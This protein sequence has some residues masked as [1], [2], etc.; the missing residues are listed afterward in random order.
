[1][2]RY[3]VQDK[4]AL[5]TGAARGIGF[6]T[7]RQLV[8]RGARVALVDLDDQAT[9]DAAAQLGD[10][11]IGFGADVT[12]AAAME[13]VVADAVAHFGRLDVVVAN[14]GI[15]PD[16]ATNR[17][18]GPAAF[19]RVLDVNVLGVYRT[20]HA[21]L[22]HVT[23]NAGHVVVIASVYAF[24]NGTILAPYAMSKAAVEQ[25]GRALRAELVAHG[26]SATVVYF[27]F[28]DTAMVREGFGSGIGQ[29]FE[30][31]FP[32]VLRKRLAPS[33]AG[34]VIV[35]GIE[36]RA[37]RVIAPKRWTV[38]AVLRGILNPGL[39]RRIGRHAATQAV[40]READQGQYS[41][42]APVQ[43]EAVRHG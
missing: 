43:L 9:R 3:S 12:D 32:K 41:S 4:V 42:A 37:A 17:S 19:E 38:Y 31:T 30:Q 6:E 23:A 11:A 18:M 8:E 24:M 39:D 36:R 2:S 13:A 5:V 25:Y 34:A 21:A 20:V 1:M 16:P 7:A 28:I 40:V 22:P 27:G 29:R 15:A 35:S 33:T 26:A 14:A 10:R